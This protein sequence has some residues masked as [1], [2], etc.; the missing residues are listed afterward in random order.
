MHR[1]WRVGISEWSALILV[2]RK[3]GSRK[4]EQAIGCGVHWNMKT[5]KHVLARDGVRKQKRKGDCCAHGGCHG[6]KKNSIFPGA[7]YPSIESQIYN[8]FSMQFYNTHIQFIYSYS[9]RHRHS[10]F[11]HHT[12]YHY[13]YFFH[14]IYGYLVSICAFVH[15]SIH[16]HTLTHSLSLSF[17]L[18]MHKFS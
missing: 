14:P 13:Y 17:S 6:K 12:L 4:R 2:V 11:Y 8:A 9:Q 7:N 1:K 10:S 5:F 18:Y 16:T 15:P 3:A